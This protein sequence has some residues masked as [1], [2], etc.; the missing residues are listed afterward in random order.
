MMVTSQHWDFDL[1]T[2]EAVSTGL[3][4]VFRSLGHWAMTSGHLKT[5]LWITWSSMYKRPVF[6][7]GVPGEK[8][9]A[10][11]PVT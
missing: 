1:G 4:A 8:S 6:D 10:N 3:A 11:A 7:D 2:L 9:R 5:G